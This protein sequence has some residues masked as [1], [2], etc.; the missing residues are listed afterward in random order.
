MSI[1]SLMKGLFIF[2]RTNAENQTAFIFILLFLVIM[3][4]LE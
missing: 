2:Q 1:K 3:K 4:V